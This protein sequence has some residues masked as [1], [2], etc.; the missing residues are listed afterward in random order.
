MRVV[1]LLIALSI[2]VDATDAFVMGGG[3]PP[4]SSSIGTLMFTSDI[5]IDGSNRKIS[6][7]SSHTF[8]NRLYMPRGGSANGRVN[9]RMKAAVADDG[10]EYKSIEQTISAATFNLIKGCVGSG[11]LSLPAGVAAIGDVPEA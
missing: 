1:N 9:T 8:D 5:I 6:K 2:F 3:S 10:D 7:K 11:V 4:S